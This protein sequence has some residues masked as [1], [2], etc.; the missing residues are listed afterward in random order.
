MSTGNKV[1][2]FIGVLA[3]VGVV[4][5]FATKSDAPASL[6]ST[7]GPSSS[8]SGLVRSIG[9]GLTG[10]VSAIVGAVEDDERSA[11]GG[12]PAPEDA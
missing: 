9:A 2:V 10:I 8:G 4:V 1:L 12:S 11:A 7:S 5:F 3:V 6:G